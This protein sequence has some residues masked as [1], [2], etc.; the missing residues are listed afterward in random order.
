MTIDTQTTVSQIMQRRVAT[1]GEDDDLSLALQLMLWR[2]IRHLPVT[3][4]GA[5]IGL[6][7]ERDVLAGATNEDTTIRAMGK[8]RD[9]MRRS[10]ES[11][12]PTTTV[13]EVAAKMAL[14]KIGCL[15]VMQGQKLVGLVTTTDVLAASAWVPVR[16]KK[17]A[18]VVQDVM[19]LNPI[20]A[21]AD[22]LLSEA[23]ARMFRNHVRH[24]PVLS[25]EGRAVGMLSVR[26]VR[27]VFG[28]PLQSN[29]THS[30]P[31]LVSSAMTSSVRTI[32]SDAPISE[33]FDVLI[34]ERFGAL[35][36][37]D[38]EERVVGMLSYLDLLAWSQP[39]KR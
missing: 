6:V 28:N 37:I 4:D 12:A 23:A 7:S 38:D 10:I 20:A 16:R 15:P 36:V 9:V 1:V 5:L 30:E 22:E 21:R 19:T 35:P 27:C 14:E 24:L 3:K 34:N 25:E 11:V 18:T 39:N 2:Q 26:D 32:P 13:A 17:E 29:V 33:A 8:V 31:P